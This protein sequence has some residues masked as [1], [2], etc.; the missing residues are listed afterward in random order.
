MILAIITFVVG[1]AVGCY[2]GPKVLAGLGQK[3]VTTVEAA[4]KKV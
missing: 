1:V 3:A 2:F 4:A